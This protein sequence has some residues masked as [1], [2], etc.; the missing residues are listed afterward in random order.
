VDLREY[1]FK[2]PFHNSRQEATDAIA[3]LVDRC[4]STVRHWAYGRVPVP[5]HLV[6]DVKAA[7][8]NKVP[9]HE[10]RPDV[11]PKS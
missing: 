7:T 10:L 3:E 4:E 11:F 8:K 2:H 6:R 5:A 1:L 9:L